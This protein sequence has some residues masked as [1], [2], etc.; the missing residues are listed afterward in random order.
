[1]NYFAHEFSMLSEKNSTTLSVVS[2]NPV[3]LFWKST[4]GT[5]CLLMYILLGEPAH[6]HLLLST[7][8][9]WA[10]HKLKQTTEFRK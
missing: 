1:M 4:V 9:M 5:K 7:I 2:L 3:F 10:L 8:E 6:R